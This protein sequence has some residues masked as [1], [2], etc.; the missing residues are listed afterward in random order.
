M[1]GGNEASGDRNSPDEAV[2]QAPAAHIN[3]H[4]LKVNVN[5]HYEPQVS[6]TSK[7]RVLGR[8]QVNRCGQAAPPICDSIAGLSDRLIV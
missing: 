8:A 4:V 7:P 1:Y 6:P 3:A 2:M 5:E